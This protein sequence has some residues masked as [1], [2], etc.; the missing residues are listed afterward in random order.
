MDIIPYK[1][2]GG[3]WC[4]LRS[5]LQKQRMQI[6]NWVT[7][8][9]FPQLPSKYYKPLW[10]TPKNVFLVIFTRR[11]FESRLENTQIGRERTRERK[12]GGRLVMGSTG[13][14]SETKEKALTL[15]ACARVCA[16]C[17]NLGSPSVCY[18]VSG[19]SPCVPMRFALALAGQLWWIGRIPQLSTRASD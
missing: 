6:L 15:C 13:T 18:A 19:H 7:A 5:T 14:T 8:M 4:V 11:G 17:R 9:V 16:Q 10:K 3:C 12:S 1:A 2:E